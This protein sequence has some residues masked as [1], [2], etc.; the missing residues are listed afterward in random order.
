MSDQRIQYD[1]EMVGAGHPT[2]S[3]TLNRLMLVEHNSDGTHAISM[4]PLGHL[5][6]LEP[7]R[8]DND[9]FYLEAGEVDIGGTSYSVSAQL[10]KQV[11]GLSADTWY[12]IYASAPSGD[13]LAATDISCTST[14]PTFSGVKVGWYSGDDRCLG[15]LKTDGSSDILSFYS[16]GGWF[17][18][19]DVEDGEFLSTSSLASTQTAVSVDG[20]ALGRLLG[21]FHWRLYGS[22]ATLWLTGGDQSDFSDDL[23]KAHISASVE[24]YGEALLL[25]DASQ[26]VDYKGNNANQLDLGLRGFQLPAGMRG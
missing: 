5:S 3:D 24:E 20:P 21:V 7:S 14:A 9:E 16:A 18:F 8:K 15:V 26:Q 4:S 1:E 19:A 13:D 6:G 25:T 10:T 11:S 12:Y 2:K 23:N 22:S 17:Y